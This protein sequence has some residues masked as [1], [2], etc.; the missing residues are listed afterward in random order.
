LDG[1]EQRL[2]V[3]YEWVPSGFHA[4]EVAA[5]LRA[6]HWLGDHVG[7][8]LTWVDENR[9]GEDYRLM[10]ADVTLQAGKGTYLK[11]EH[12]RTES[13]AAPVF[14]SDNGGL[15]FAR[16]NPDGMRE[17]EASALE[18]RINLREL[19]LST[20]DWQ[21]G[22][23]WRRVDRGYSVSRF[24][25]GQAVE[26][27]GVETLARIGQAILQARHSRAGRGSDVLEQ[28]QVSGEWRL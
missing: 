18:A 23:W 3:D 14:F 12:S 2:I 24:D 16:L 9:A 19:G 7:L 22:G 11:L 28:T 5:G 1:L 6:R 15:D 20:H 13:T 27:Y 26:E 25:T 8:G 21:L 4:D 10:A 17:G